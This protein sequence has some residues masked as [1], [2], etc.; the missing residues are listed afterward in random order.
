MNAIQPF[1]GR[2]P[3]M[4]AVGNHECGGTNRQHYAMRLGG[5][6]NAARNSGGGQGGIFPEGD[7]LWYSFDAGLVHAGPGRI[8]SL[9]DTSSTSYHMC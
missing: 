5:L 2:K 3:L 7:A 4:G 8:A 1:A 9:Y 6:A